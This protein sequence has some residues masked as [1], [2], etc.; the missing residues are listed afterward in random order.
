MLSTVEDASSQ[1]EKLGQ[2]YIALHDKG[3]RVNEMG[4]VKSRRKEAGMPHPQQR[5]MQRGFF[6]ENT[7]YCETMFWEFSSK[8]FKARYACRAAFL[9]QESG[10]EHG[11]PSWEGGA[12]QNQTLILTLTSNTHA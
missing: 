12:E 8:L 6:Q 2:S 1:A 3:V 4:I 5:R 7:M 10:D 11:L 9:M